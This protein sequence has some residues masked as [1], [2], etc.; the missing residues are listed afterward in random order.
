MQAILTEKL[1]IRWGR[2]FFLGAALFYVVPASQIHGA[3][4]TSAQ[5][6]VWS[7]T[8]T[9]SGG[10]V[11]TQTDTV[12]IIVPH[13]V[14]IDISTA[15]ASTTTINGTLKFN[16]SGDNEF[17]LIAGSISVNAGGTLDMGTAASPIPQGTTA[18]LTLPTGSYSGQYA[19]NINVGGNFLVYGS[20]KTP[21]TTVTSDPSGTT[22]NV[23]PA[24]VVN[25]S[26]GDVITIGQ[27]DGISNAN[28]TERRTIAGITGGNITLGSF[29]GVGP[30]LT[31]THFSS[32]TCQVADLTRNVVIRSTVTTPVT[33]GPFVNSLVTN[34]TSFVVAYGEFAYLGDSTN[35]VLDIS[36]SPP[37]NSGSISSSTFHDGLADGISIAAG[38]TI[39]LNSNLAYNNSGSG[40]AIGSEGNNGD[41]ATVI[42]NSAVANGVHGFVFNSNNNL[43]VISNSAYSNGWVNSGYSN[44]INEFSGSK[45]TLISN[46]SY[47]NQGDG[48]D[49]SAN[50]VAV[51]NNSF[52][53]LSAGI[54]VGNNAVLIANN[55]YANG[56]GGIF[57]SAASGV[58]GVGNNIGY[59]SSS[60]SVPDA[61]S[62]ILFDPAQTQNL[63]FKNSPINPSVGVQ[64]SGFAK[65]N[66]Y[67]VNYSTSAG[68]VQVY[69]NYKV[70][71]S[72]LTLDYASQ[73]Y[74]STTTN[75]KNVRGG[76]AT[77]NFTISALNDMNVVS[78][79]VTLQYVAGSTNKWVVTG[80]STGV[81]CSI[82]ISANA[83][84]PASN[85]Q[86][87]LA[88]GAT[89][90]NNG[91]REDFALIAASNDAN[92]PKK[93]QFGKSAL[94]NNRSKIEI[95]TKAGF[96]AVGVSTA[97][98]L[99]D[100]ISS[101]ST[102][103]TF[104]DSGAFT[105]AFAS[106]THMDELGIQ[107]SSA[108]VSGPWSI[109]DSTFDVTG[110]SAGAT[111]AS[112]FT[113]N[114]VTQS[115]INII[116]V[117]YGSNSTAA[118]PYNYTILG[119]STGLSWNNYSY[120]GGLTGHGNERNDPANLITWDG[121]YCGTL[122][123][124]ASSSWSIASTWDFG[125]VP[126]SCNAVIIATGT[127]VT[128]NIPSAIASTTTIKGTLQYSRSGDNEF[129]LVG[130]SMS[131][132]AGGTLDMGTN[133]SPIPQGTTAYLTLSS[134]TTA[135]Q[136]GLV[137]NNGGN[138]SVYGSTKTPWSTLTTGVVGKGTTG[139]PFTVTDTTGWQVGDTITIDTETAIITA[140]PG[141]NQVTI[142]QSL[143]QVHVATYG[144][145]VANLTHNV[146]VRSSGTNTG[147]NTAYIENLAKNATSFN[148]TYGDFQYLGANVAK[149]YG[150][151]F[152]SAK[153]SIS[154]S[155]VRNGYVGINTNT[156][157]N[158]LLTWNN[159]YANAAQ[160][161]LLT[162]N[163]N[164]VSFNNAYANAAV[165]FNDIPGI[166]INGNNNT[167][168]S[169]NTFSHLGTN[170]G[171]GGIEFD[172]GNNN[173]VIANNVYSNFT[174]G[175][176]F[177]G[178][179]GNTMISDNMFGNQNNGGGS[180]ESGL[181]LYNSNNNGVLCVNCH[182]GYTGAGLAAADGKY[183]FSMDNS[184]NNTFI[185]KNSLV[186]PSPGI[187]TPYFATAGNYLLLYS[188]NTGVA[189]VYGDY[190]V[191]GSTVTLDYA[192]QLYA[193][194]ATTPAV[195]FG[196]ETAS[197][198]VVNTT[199][200]TNAVSQLATL[201]YN[202]SQWVVTGS[203]TGFI[204]N[205]S[206]GTGD[207][208]SPVQFNL[209]V[210]SGLV[211][212][213]TANFA[214]IAASK[215]AG[216]Q[217]KLQF[218]ATTGSGFNNNRSKIRV[219]A[220]A[221][222][223]AV[224]VSMAPTLID[225]ISSAATYYTFV[226]SGAFTV[227]FASF[228][229]M[230]ELGIQLSSAG[231]SGP[232]SINNSTFDVTG[233]SAGTTTASLI[234]LNGVT[235]ST[236]NIL[237]VTYGSNS[238]AATPYNY[239][240]LGSSVGLSWNNYSYSGGLTGN[241]HEFSDPGNHINW[242]GTFCSTITS[243]TNGNWSSPGTW[244]VGL[245]PTSC[246]PVYIVSGTTVTLNT[247]AQASTITV[248]GTLQYARSGDN[249]LTQ[250]GGNLYVNLGGT[251]DMGTSSST[252]PSGT[253][254]YL[255]LSSGTTAG[256]YGLIVNDGGNFLVYGSSKTPWVQGTGTASGTNVPVA[257][258][259]LNW[260]VGDTVT[261]D[262][263]AVKITVIGGSA[264]TVSPA[265]TLTHS[266]PT[267]VADL[268]RNVLIRSSGTATA[269]NTAYIQ[270]LASN[271]TSFNVN[272][273]EFAYLGANVAGAYGI[274]FDGIV[275]P[276]APT[277]SISSSTLR[278]GFDGLRIRT[279]QPG[280]VTLTSNLVY[281]NY[282][283]GI[284]LDAS[285]FEYRFRPRS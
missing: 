246:N 191:S 122:T 37:S 154:S 68:V 112:L 53:N 50:S 197:G 194:T 179:S 8:H 21:F 144:V 116:G 58:I 118:T 31:Y 167:L 17:T 277:G 190:S 20:T 77:G 205:A 56:N 34:A 86:F 87:H 104:V 182:L 10:A 151:D 156:S 252:I 70:S 255:T 32:W 15:T 4:I 75:L 237:G 136:Y 98:T 200:D 14:T 41:Y 171:G 62:E 141:S 108:G 160:G 251:L 45:N 270:T 271:T 152:E 23:V 213:D 147:T 137:I 109:N 161:A 224:G 220:A 138:F 258:S 250:V 126:S 214:L 185:F 73:L 232:W 210:P 142:T 96:H 18:Y 207:C 239:T 97:P 83:D 132:N 40:I 29:G 93:L 7:D 245:V 281:A 124:I 80:S 222:F 192:N 111:A 16:R 183:E 261:V 35:D 230:D 66:S 60:V 170:V 76:Q 12:N 209:T 69:G 241:G 243:I 276:G 84:C 219:A 259:G 1:R 242:N 263:E 174:Y 13:I 150:I 30:S 74:V 188:T 176:G 121:T 148:L 189:Q 119:S 140:L 274:T 196:N 284:Y 101:A 165:V 149:E 157:N 273:A 88:I 131:V 46:L 168:L 181:E 218:A 19:L 260:N 187:Y 27:A 95:S 139:V 127:T 51:G 225:W 65:A 135:G 110:S 48:I 6:G 175:M 36:G 143:G 172:V 198:F 129:T 134:G 257:T 280:N 223:H 240:I 278:N 103:Y 158:T 267:V 91:D 92:Q 5:T 81:L 199:S 9:W 235:Q 272:Y 249:E 248:T 79:L 264:L 107:L 159:L 233:S 227:A 117:T 266:T 247:I 146:V 202:G 102:Y 89:S 90:A 204:C 215:D 55:F 39:S 195:M 166:E 67:F 184:V 164:T 22:L 173:L 59:S 177:S 123:S 43:V 11:P 153:G 253:T 228:T 47:S 178:G 100:W 25:W 275:A 180:S 283:F 244:D 169:N 229:H 114:G 162:G 265:L 211:I 145:V 64:T 52:A 212:G 231:V 33:G 130:G 186:N 208:G 54:E 268:T 2:F 78:Q 254:A 99:I 256:Q 206:V 193:S 234:T 217:K 3:V 128:L 133:A 26:T 63:T 105:V 216:T 61:P 285:T 238:T 115:T 94:T 28:H 125:V 42:S 203:S 201:V 221:G 226:D 106:F 24:D 279:D 38:P 163:N 49:I 44:G 85:T 57:V 269:S 236:I 82:A 155:T 120:S 113:L 72:T 71:A 262:T 282:D